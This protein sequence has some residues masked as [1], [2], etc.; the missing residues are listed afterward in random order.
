MCQE[1]PWTSTCA[2]FCGG[3][4]YDATTIIT[5]AHCCDPAKNMDDP[6]VIAGD[7]DTSQDSGHEQKRGISKITIHPDWLGEDVSFKNDVCLL[8]LDSPLKLNDQVKSISL[9]ENEPVPDT[10]CI[11]SGWG[12]LTVCNFRISVLMNFIVD[13]RLPIS[14]RWIST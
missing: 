3:S 13:Y 12:T 1:V 10:K 14:G 9:D 8:T 11:V 7:L 6:K 5:A 2:V 4:I